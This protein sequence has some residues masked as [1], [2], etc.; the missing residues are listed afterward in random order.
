MYVSQIT[1]LHTLNLMLS[2]NY[3]STQLEEKQTTSQPN[4]RVYFL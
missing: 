2:V 4:N 3:I 1:T